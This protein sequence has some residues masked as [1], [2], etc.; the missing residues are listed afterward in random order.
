MSTGRRVGPSFGADVFSV[1]LR[2]RAGVV[3]AGRV[4]VGVVLAQF[5]PASSRLRVAV[6][7]QQPCLEDEHNLASRAFIVDVVVTAVVIPRVVRM[8]KVNNCVRAPFVRRGLLV[9]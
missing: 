8:G 2:V 1:A 5:E 6:P 3:L 4:G 9:R 7:G